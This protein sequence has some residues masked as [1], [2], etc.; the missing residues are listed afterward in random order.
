MIYAIKAFIM[1]SSCILII[2]SHNYFA[3]LNSRRSPFSSQPALIHHH[4]LFFYLGDPLSFTVVVCKSRGGRGRYLQMPNQW[5]HTEENV[6]LQQAG[7]ALWSSGRG[8][9]SQ[10]PNPDG[11]CDSTLMNLILRGSCTDYHSCWEFSYTMAMSYPEEIFYNTLALALAHLIFY[12]IPI[13]GDFK[14]IVENVHSLRY[15]ALWRELR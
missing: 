15:Q 10:A 4:V 6:F 8:V 9:A 3:L 14:F 12:D 13:K 1:T 2:S 7:T 5:L 11:L